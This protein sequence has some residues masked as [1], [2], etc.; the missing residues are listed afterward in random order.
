MECSRIAIDASS[1]VAAQKF[2]ATQRHSQLRCSSRTTVKFFCA[3]DLF[4]TRQ[5]THSLQLQHFARGTHLPRHRCHSRQ[6]EDQHTTP[7]PSTSGRPLP[8]VSRQQFFQNCFA[9]S[10]ALAAA[11]AGIRAVAPVV[12]AGW[13]KTEA[14]AVQAL[15]QSE[16]T[17]Y[18]D[19]IKQDLHPKQQILLL[20]TVNRH[21]C[22]CL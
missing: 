22:H 7:E 20:Y 21:V 3:S 15:L 1:F 19:Q 18:S 9:V 11:G 4:P 8:S 2:T 13:F 14:A 16:Y 10:A 17:Y 6:A 12:S 5:T